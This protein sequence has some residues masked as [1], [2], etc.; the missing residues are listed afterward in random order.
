MDTKPLSVRVKRQHHDVTPDHHTAAG[1]RNPWP[2]WHKPTLAEKAN[3]LQWLQDDDPCLQLATSHLQNPRPLKPESG[4]LPSFASVN[5]W[6]NSTG[7]Q[8]AQLLKLE[9]P[10]FGFDASSRVKATWLGHATFLVQLRPLAPSGRPVRCLFDPMFSMRCSPTQS[11]GPIRSYP[12]PCELGALPPIDLVVISH[13][14]L[15]HLDWG[16]IESLWKLNKDHV[17]F[18][19]PLG[20]K[21]WFINAGIEEASIEELDWWDTAIISHSS[22]G[23]EPLTVTCTPAQHSSGRSLADADTTLWSSWFLEQP[24]PDPYRVFFS[25]DTGFQFHSSH[26]WPPRPPPER[27]MSGSSKSPSGAISPDDQE[28]ATFPACP[29]F[30]DIRKR[31][32]R[33]H[34]LLLPVSV[35][36]TYAY[37]RSLVPL[38]R[39]LN[40]FPRHTDGMAAAT[41]LPPWDAVR[42]FNIMTKP[43][44]TTSV[45][46][47]TGPSAES[48]PPSVAVAMHWGTFATDPVE[49]LR[50]LGRLEWACQAQGVKFARRAEDRGSGRQGGSV[51]VQQRTLLALNQGQSIEV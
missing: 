20:N 43:A 28:D 19:V 12:P 38:P 6:P 33:P 16:S 36:A 21:A 18:L 27:P 37:L 49:I 40:P 34:L 39:V 15:D 29:A 26:L 30:A 4:Q 31:L 2:S 14:H 1:F 3:S 24:L 45:P 7:A 46:E 25:G 41:H 50:T 11:L 35:G 10:D 9:D 47:A 48:G 22:G 13:N 42:V 5:G 44:E 32:G 17:H 23:T 8:A 51:D